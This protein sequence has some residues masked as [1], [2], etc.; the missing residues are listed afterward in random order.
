MAET[1]K[2]EW[3]QNPNKKGNRIFIESP[4]NVEMGGKI[5]F[6]RICRTPK[7]KTALRYLSYLLSV[8]I[9]YLLNIWIPKLHVAMTFSDTDLSHADSVVVYGADDNI[10]I[11]PLIREKTSEKNLQVFYYRLF[12]YYYDEISQI[13]K[14]AQFK[15]EAL[16]SNQIHQVYG[17]GLSENVVN[18][19]GIFFGK[20]LTDI[21]KK[22]CMTLMVEE[23]LS[24]FYIFQVYS[25]IIWAFDDYAVYAAMIVGFSACS[26][27]FTLYETIQTRKK[28]RDMSFYQIDVTVYRKVN[29]EPIK[30]IV[31]SSELV[32]G[33]LIE[34]P[35]SVVMPCDAILLNGSCIM[36]E[37]MLT[38]ESIPVIK[39]SLPYSDV[40]Y[41]G[42]EDKQYTL[43]AGTKC[44]QARY[45]S[46]NAVLG[47]VTLTGFGTVKGELIRTMLFPKPTDFKF[48]SDS[49][50]FIGIL[51]VMA[52]IGFIYDLPS[53]IN[54]GE[55]D[56]I[57]MI[58][59]KASEIVTV[60]VPPAL[61]TCM[62][63]G[64]SVALS[65]LKK[66]Q[67]FCISP[68]KINETGRVSVMC[69]DKTGTLT[70]DGL[71]LMGV[72]PV[73]FD[74]NSKTLKFSKLI[75]ETE[76][77]NKKLDQT[78]RN[79]ELANYVSIEK[80][81]DRGSIYEK[82]H[83]FPSEQLL[84]I[85]AVCHSLTFVKD[86]MIGDPLD[87][88]MFES[89]KWVFEE[90]DQ[91][92]YDSLVLAVVK[93]PADQGSVG[94]DSAP[95]EIGIIR[96]FEFSSKLQRMSV[97]VKNLQESG[98]K[99][100]IKGSPEKIRELC[101]PESVPDNFHH[102]L[103]KYTESGFRVLACAT[104]SIGANYRKIM[105]AQREDIEKEFTFIGFLIMENK[106]KPITTPTIDLLHSAEIR[107]IMVTGDNALT[108]I[109]VARQCHIVGHNQRIFLGDLSE[110]K[111]NGK[112]VIAWKDFDFSERRLDN[113][114]DPEVDSTNRTNYAKTHVGGTY[115]ELLE[116]H[117]KLQANG[118][119][120]LQEKLVHSIKSDNAPTEKT[121]QKVSLGTSNLVDM[122]PPFIDLHANED[123]SIAVTGKAFSLI[124]HE[125][126]VNN[127]PQYKYILQKLLKKCAVFARMHP[128]EKALMIKHMMMNPKNIVGMCGDG[129]NDVGA[130]KTANVG[131]SLSEAEASIA[132][133]FTS[134]IQDISCIPTLLREGRAGLS[135]SYQAFKYMALYSIIQFTTVTILYGDLIELT[136]WAYYHIDIFIILSLSATMAMSDAYQHLTK[137]RPTGRL[138][139]V[140]ILSS[141]IGQGF[142]QIIF[143][144][145]TYV[146]L[147]SQG[148]Y[149]PKQCEDDFSTQNACFENT[150]LYI[151]T[152]YQYWMTAF[153]F[154]VGK[155]FRQPFYT[156]FWFTLSLIV[157]LISN[158]LVNFNPFKWRF[159]DTEVTD[160]LVEFEP[161]WRNALFFI[162][163]FNCFV[164]AIW[165][166]LVVKY[167]ATSWKNYRIRRE[168]A[169][170][171]KE[172]LYQAPD[173]H[174]SLTVLSH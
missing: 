53:W 164:T 145:V 59:I 103:E 74:K 91:Q 5:Q 131:V 73:F 55:D 8:F 40:Y 127:N 52:V 48:Y 117:S 119:K 110:K 95:R 135:T 45:Y 172:S 12:K 139:S 37:S 50:K 67:I 30:L 79:I 60:T 97:I 3:A 109:S 147:K 2:S 136:N 84:E 168:K 82:T 20:N 174:L 26:I 158:I 141:V 163:L 6:I 153:V 143:Q 62:Q 173:V 76:Q 4:E 7:W 105:A 51:A 32:P 83:L 58:I 122:D 113:N 142:I 63:I 89:T 42:R 18:D 159:I 169:Q 49:F 154:I 101:K 125:V 15:I 171:R 86:K 129:A 17:Q 137:F 68:N 93:P 54:S 80:K 10:E 165:E 92:K 14:P 152:T 31:N 69:F 114:L 46:G 25:I 118:R 124:L 41:N 11:V 56:V 133:P 146:L 167:I 70:E 43:Y 104:K 36:N 130:L 44:I 47:L 38:G 34:I 126:E 65:R 116:N 23:V 33:D 121:R 170:E 166:L 134:N 87:L 85:M 161:S 88:K 162:S 81:S 24:P 150:S 115:E 148:W 149:D 98:F 66:K 90:N 157:L 22:S 94:D 160:N 120:S 102:I 108:A 144:I 77:L 19:N 78:N 57:T 151:L 35:E 61:P 106:L 132:A 39:N 21:P 107:T 111:V 29:G 112:N 100:H 96:R 28:L 99:A 9:M 155:P 75:Q 1:L 128:D 123:Y 16:T 140:E 71:D 156:N 64:I 13:F 27:A 138:V 72:R